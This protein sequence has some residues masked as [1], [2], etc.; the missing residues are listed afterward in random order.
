[1]MQAYRIIWEPK[2]TL[3][4]LMTLSAGVIAFVAVMIQI[5]SSRR[6]TERLL[7]EEKKARAAEEKR[8]LEAVARALSFEIANFYNYYRTRVRPLLDRVNTE[9]CVPP[10]LSALGSNAFSVYQGNTGRL[11]A[12]QNGVVESVVQFY[13]LAELLLTSICDYTSSLARELER[14][15]SVPARSAPRQFLGQ[16]QEVM[17]PTDAAAIQALEKLCQVAGMS[18]EALKLRS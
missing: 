10:S 4:G 11:G 7:A 16:I 5:Q 2:L 9:T 13:G 6:D 12:F 15:G 8:Q 14:Q 1:M 3:D 18:L 17:Y